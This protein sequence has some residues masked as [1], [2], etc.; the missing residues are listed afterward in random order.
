[1]SS[2]AR[3]CA[4]GREQR[5]TVSRPPVDA[6]IAPQWPT[7]HGWREPQPPL[8]RARSFSAATGPCGR[9]AAAARIGLAR[10]RRGLGTRRRAQDRRARGQGRRARRARGSARPRD[11]ATSAACA[12]T[13][14]RTTTVTSTSPT[15]TCPAGRCA[16]RSAP[17]SSATTRPSRRRRRCSTRSRTRTR[18]GSSTATSSRRTCCSRDGDR[19]SVRLLDFGLAQ[20]DEAET[21]TAPATCPARSR[22]SRRSGSR[23]STATGASDV[24]AVGVMLW[25]ALA[26]G[27]PFWKASL[28]ESA[29]AIE[30]GAPPLA[31]RPAR[32]AE[33]AARGGRTARSRST[34]GDGRR[35]ALAELLRAALAERRRP[36]RPRLASGASPAPTALPRSGAAAAGLAALSRRLDRGRR[37]RSTRA[38]GAPALG[39]LA[40]LLTLWRPRAGLALALAV[41]VLPLG[42]VSLALGVVYAVARRRLA[43]PLRARAARRPARR[44]PGPLLA[45]LGALGLLPLAVAR[46]SARPLRRAAAAARR[47]ARRRPRRRP[48]RRARSRSPATRRPPARHRAAAR[49]SAR[50]RSRSDALAAIRRSR[51][52]AAALGAPPRRSPPYA[53][54]AAAGPSRSSA[55]A[56]LAAT[57]L[58]APASPWRRWSA[59]PG[60]AC[61]P[62]LG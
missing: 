17:A 39:R 57:L 27:H 10:A 44:P 16:R 35:R 14:S 8:P 58:P 34:R 56:F 12:P 51:V 21:L 29:R 13:R 52:E 42:N 53:A 60:T 55:A 5:V 59:S 47:R 43:R 25:E 22:T 61:A 26:G 4:W 62:A 40:G 18:A 46:R 19:V 36:V 49:A 50:S 3:S 33:A 28:L 23:A 7:A 45:P 9:S 54:R 41:P 15:S 20:M 31:L 6:G 1:M 48:A 37:C 11:S 2:N 24:W 30:A 32:P 38:A